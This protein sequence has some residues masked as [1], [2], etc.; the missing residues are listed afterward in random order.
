MRNTAFRYCML[1]G[2]AALLTI[3]LYY[4]IRYG[5]V[6][7]VALSN[8][9]ITPGLQ[10]S[11]RALWLAF[12]CQALLVGALYVVV[13]FRPQSVTRE[14]I[15]IFGMLQLVEAVL[16]FHFAGVLWMATLLVLVAACVMVGAVLWPSALPPEAETPS[17]PDAPAPEAATA[18]PEE[19]R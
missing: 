5:V 7:G 8:S 1:I 10:A 16:L 9:T 2:A 12:A 6:L 15:V 19:P 14:V 17:A 3:S 11:I 13:A 18:V 4:F